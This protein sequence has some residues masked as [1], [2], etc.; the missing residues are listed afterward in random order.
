VA[1]EPGLFADGFV[2]VSS[3]ELSAGDEVVV[4]S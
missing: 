4:P 1:V 3:D 2:S